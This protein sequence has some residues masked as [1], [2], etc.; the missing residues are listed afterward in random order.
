M[1]IAGGEVRVLARRHRTAIPSGTLAAAG[2]TGFTV[3]PVRPASRT[4]SSSI[5][6]RERP[7]PA[8]A[9]PEP[10]RRPRGPGLAGGAIVADRLTCRFGAFTAVDGV[11]LT[12]DEGEILGLLGPNGAGKTTLIKMLCGLQ[13]P[14]DGSAVVAGFD[15]RRARA[16]LRGHI[17]YMSQRF[18]LYRD[19]T[20]LENLRLSAGLYGIP[21]ARRQGRIDA[22]LSSLGLERLADRPPRGAA[23]RACASG[24]RSPARSCTSR[25]VLFL[26]EPTA[27]VDP[28]A[29]RQF[30][31]LVHLLAH[32]HGVAVLV[33][34]HYMDEAT[35]CD[36]LGFMHEGR[37]VGLGT[38]VGADAR[39]PRPPAGRCSRWTRRSSAAPSR[40]CRRAFPTPCSTAATS[41]GRPGSPSADRRAA[42]EALAAAGLAATV[43]TR[44]LSM[45]DTFVS[46]LRAAGLG[47]A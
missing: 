34:T 2:L 39:G 15:V 43:E 18:S 26:D 33:S 6:T 7:A 9:P 16:A 35:H 25:R 36:R 32:Q 1:A 20:V 40:C 12:V 30:W 17:G 29:R 22:L 14:A 13:A 31:D 27:G 21:R 24:W 23:A 38:P 45:E 41:A 5:V 44:P 10:A 3:E 8:G 42:R 46:V 37:L 4:S 47:R 11:S 19:Q 28:L